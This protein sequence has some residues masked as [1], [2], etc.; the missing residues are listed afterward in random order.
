MK[1]S[2]YL[3]TAILC[4]LGFFACRK[5]FA[6]PVTST[7]Y[8]Y[9]VVEGVINSGADS[10]IIKLSRTV[11]ISSKERKPETGARITVESDQ[12]TTYALRETVNGTYIAI[13]LNLPLSGKYR[14]HIF[15]AVNK[16]Y[17]SDFVQNKITPPIDS[18]P[19]KILEAGVQFYVNTHDANNNTRYYRWEYGEAWTY[20]SPFQS[21][22][23]YKNG[24]V[25]G[26]NPDSSINYCYK[27]DVPDNN[28]FVSS[29]DKLER[30][31]IYKYPLGYTAGLSWKLQSQYGLTVRQY[32]LT[33]D[34][35]KY[36]RLLKTNTEQLGT[37]FDAQPAT[38]LTNLHSVTNPREP[39][40]G[41]ISVSTSTLKRIFFTNRDFNFVVIPPHGNG[42]SFTCGEDS[43]FL[44]PWNTRAYRI[45]Q[46]VGSGDSLLTQLIL[47]PK[48]DTT[49]GY[50]YANK[51]CVDC[52]LEG[53]TTVKPSYWP[54]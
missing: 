9:L 11:P 3:V 1:T 6:P 36:W 31:V 52:R 19:Y 48:N 53:G 2:V 10:T 25:S 7:D 28:V 35:Y 34:A 43:V 21:V 32:A 4:V 45:Q 13:G 27:F 54:F 8:S 39:V 46:A 26:R 29:S 42:G 40:I 24:V 47:N 51:I 18:I 5:P 14:L 12:N 50:Y 33:A 15:T 30:D 17:I 49:I 38:S 41:Y 23:T 37:I 44:N 20:Y 16:E 22:L